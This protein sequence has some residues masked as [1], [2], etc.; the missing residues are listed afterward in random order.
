[1]A[2][3]VLIL[4]APS[5]PLLHDEIERC[6]AYGLEITLNLHYFADQDSVQTHYAGRVQFVD[7]NCHDTPSLIGAVV[8]AGGYSVLKTRLNIPLGAALINAAASPDLGS[9]LQAIAQA[10][11]GLNHIDLKAAAE[12]GVTVLNT[13]GANATAVAEYALAQTLFLSR[14]L[15]LYNAKTHQG[16]WSKGLLAPAPQI[17]ELT[18]GLVGTGRIAQSLA[19]KALALGMNVIATGSERFTQQAAANLGLQWRAS[20][21][22]L[23]EEADVVSI[24]TPLTAQ[25]KGLFGTAAFTRMKPGSILINT[26]RGGIVD[27]GQL[28]TFMQRFP[29][30]IKGVAIDTFARE[31]DQFESPLTGVANAIL[32]PHIAGNTR[33]AISEASRQIVDHIHAFRQAMLAG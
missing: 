22:A 1:M 28:A 15:N 33:T 2:F 21:D 14:D 29:G 11:V 13:P 27:E 19:H 3:P 30:H 25:T 31:K 6:L 32:T 12:R 17:A 18:L 24:H 10:G 8:E 26:A 20:L 16:Q 9:P 23:L 5:P 7:I 4:D